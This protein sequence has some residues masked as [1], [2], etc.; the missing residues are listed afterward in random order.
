[1]KLII[2]ISFL[3]AWSSIVHA[4]N[5]CPN[6]I[7]TNPEE[8]SSSTLP[9]TDFG[10]GNFI[11]NDPRFINS[12]D[13]TTSSNIQLQNMQIN[14]NMYYLHNASASYYG[15]IYNGE[16]MTTENGWELMLYNVGSYPDQTNNP[17]GQSP[18][19]P[20]I[21][22]YNRFTG[23]LRVFA[24][25]GD[26]FLPTGLSFDGVVVSVDFDQ[27]DDKVNGIL[28]L[29]DGGDRALDKTTTALFSKSTAFHTNSSKK[30]FSADIQLTYDPCICFYPVDLRLNFRFLETLE[31][32]LY[33]RSITV[34]DNIANG[35]NLLTNNFL[36][37]SY[38]NGIPTD[39]QI[40]L[41]KVMEDFVDD[42]IAKMEKYKADLAAVQEYNKELEKKIAV[43]KVFKFVIVQGGAFTVAA[44]TAQPWFAGLVTDISGFI[45]HIGTSVKELKGYRTKLK[46]A[47][48]KF[49]GK[50]AD[51]FIKK[52]F[53]KK[54]DP[55]KPSPPMASFTEMR[56]NGEISNSTL[57]PGSKFYTPGSYGSV[58]TGSPTILNPLEYPIYN[59]AV[60]TFALLNSPKI[61]AYKSKHE[62]LNEYDQEFDFYPYPGAPSPLTKH[63][64]FK[65]WNGNYQFELS[66]D[67]YYAMN[68]IGIQSHTVKVALEVEGVLVSNNTWLNNVYIDPSG[69]ANLTSEQV[70]TNE[71]YPL[72]VSNGQG[73][74]YG[75]NYCGAYFPSS[76]CT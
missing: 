8:P 66:N 57:I 20:Y 19:V 37:N 6:E 56:M 45:P 44:I 46:T 15:Y 36:S 1:M 52:N 7:T 73:F 35:N 43:A 39:N 9:N 12:F 68:D 27:P 72:V 23:I 33:G 18:D 53:E 70:E 67:L 71:F 13:W 21:A 76:A 64:G 25:Y 62:I 5:N 69:F 50:E 58:G 2:Y 59:N 28:R 61:K 60:G 38:F 30:W 48:A 16:P 42:Y 31:L 34:Q 63:R 74:N 75:A 4:Q 41:Y 49:F 47:A 3:F 11:P 55:E 40:V 32:D 24:V 22:L 10:G 26:G 17:D 51:S 65:S 29:R 54:K 14:Q